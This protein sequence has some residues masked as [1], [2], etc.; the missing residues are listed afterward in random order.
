MEKE[1]CQNC[2]ERPISSGCFC[3]KCTTKMKKD[4]RQQKSESYWRSAE[5]DF[6]DT[7]G[8]SRAR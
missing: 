3:G 6:E 5:L 7:F 4:K 2:C 8:D 1:L